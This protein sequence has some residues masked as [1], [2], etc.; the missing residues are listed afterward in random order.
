MYFNVPQ[1]VSI[2]DKIAFQLTA[3][4]LGWFALGG[5]ILFLIW[6]MV[7]PAVFF[8]WVFIIGAFAVA[9]AF[10]KPFG[11][12]FSSF[13]VSSFKHLVS[14]KILVWERRAKEEKFEKAPH[15]TSAGKKVRIDRFMKEK[16]LKRVDD[17]ADVL[18]KQSRI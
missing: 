2:E 18:D 12:P 1:F 17:F 7:T 5:V 16:E 13:L 14:P 6:Q 10:F 8:V 11:I 3:K 15:K 4:Q 9:L